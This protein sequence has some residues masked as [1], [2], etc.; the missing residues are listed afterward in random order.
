VHPLV[1]LAELKLADLARPGEVLDMPQLLRFVSE[2]AEQPVIEID[3]LNLDMAAISDVMS[4]AFAQRHHILAVAVTDE[5]VEVASAEPW[6]TQWEK[7]LEHAV[8]R[9]VKR[10]LADPRE[11]TKH[12]R[13]FYAMAHS[14]QGARSANRSSH[15][16]LANLESMLELG[17]K[18]EP[19]ANDQHIVGVVD[20]L[21]QYAFEQR[22]SDIHMEPRRDVGLV[23]LRIDGV[24]HK[25]Y[26][27]P[28]AVAAAVTSRF[29]I[30]ARLDVAEKRRPQ[31]G[32]LKT[33]TPDG[34]E[35]ELR[36]S[37]LPTAFGEKL[38]MRI[39]D[40][41]VLLKSFEAL[42]LRGDDFER[43]ES[44]TTA[45]TGIVLVTGP[46]GSG[47]TTTLYSTLR[48]LA[49][50]EVNVCTIEDP[51]E[52]VEPAFNQMQVN[53]SIDLDFASGVRALMRQD[54]DIIMVGEIRD[55]ETANMAIQAALTGHL[56]LST[57]HTNDS[58]G[59]ISR[60]IEL[61]VPAFLIRATV[62]G[63]MSQRLVRTLCHQCKRLETADSLAWL[64]LV[65]ND[66]MAMPEQLYRP[67]GCKHC[68]ET[69]YL[70][71]EGIYEVLVASS[72]VQD[73]ITEHH[74]VPAIRASAMTGGMVPLR[75]AGAEK[76]IRGETT[77]EEVLRVAPAEER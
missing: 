23:R 11:I 6:I 29:K 15:G 66:A 62:R 1:H 43:W 40:P 13:E 5:E 19:D 59:A 57:L 8:R 53:H 54:P 69:G 34:A 2:Q 71:R 35:V 44:M 41:E 48:R 58:P 76:V 24:L 67:T 10:V 50:A 74:S 30:L 25:V 12:T 39:F 68:R 55:L 9:R 72:D 38:V 61:G 14:V 3:P 20:W 17:V 7:D 75:L 56:V 42:G 77:I 51:I 27:L 49:T 46:T 32:R 26:E 33:R 73:T 18:G 4:Q 22:A 52:M 63:V 65:G 47:K 64:A 60:L 28:A 31:D 16:R 36:L 37:T 70:G 45:G 21:L